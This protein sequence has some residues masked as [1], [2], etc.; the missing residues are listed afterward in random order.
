MRIVFIGPPGAGKGTQCG[1]LTEEFGIPHLS[2]GEMLRK[3][4]RDSPLG[5]IV[6]SYIDHGRL[7]P[8]Y[9]VLPIVT[10][11]LSEAD[12]SQ[13]CLLDGFPRTVNQAEKLDQFLV[14]NN[15]E[16]DVVLNLTV[17][18]E[19]LIARLLRRAEQE[20]RVDD[21]DETIAARLE[22]FRN[23]TAPVL[24]HY[25]QQGL[26]KSIDGSNSPDEVFELI[27]QAVS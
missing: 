4:E 18:S 3:T 20:N 17:P 16:L 15:W 6:A 27:R 26:V 8:D 22:I 23:Q 2:T 25:K 14:E 19:D 1:R 24:D 7:A 21:T 13:G 5:K 11:R 9:L 10:Q 12:C